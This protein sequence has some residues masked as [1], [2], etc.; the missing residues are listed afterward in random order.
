MNERLYKVVLIHDDAD[1]A[2][3]A[4]EG[5]L[6]DLQLA[7]PEGWAEFAQEMWGEYKPFFFPSTRGIFKSR[8]AAQRRAAI[9]TYWGGKAKVLE[10]TPQ[11]QSIESANREREQVRLKK[12]IQRMQDELDAQQTKLANLTNAEGAR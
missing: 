8:S 7:D 10:C 1:D 4:L 9:I 5:E 3:Y 2:P 12:R 11:W 6:V